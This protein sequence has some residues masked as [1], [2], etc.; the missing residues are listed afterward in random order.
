M[1]HRNSDPSFPS[2]HASVAGAA[3]VGLLL[4]SRLLAAATTMAPVLLAGARVYVG[5]HYPTDVLAGLLLGGLVAMLLYVLA[6]NRLARLIT[7]AGR[8]RLRPVFITSGTC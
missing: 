2:G 6:H 7:A 3:T 8:S 5:V 4:V 1:V